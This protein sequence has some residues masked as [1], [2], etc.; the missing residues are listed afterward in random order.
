MTAVRN[1]LQQRR[2]RAI[3]PLLWFRCIRCNRLSYAEKIA[4]ECDPCIIAARGM[5]PRLGAVAGEMSGA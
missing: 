2:P 5:W 4:R 1:V 3:N